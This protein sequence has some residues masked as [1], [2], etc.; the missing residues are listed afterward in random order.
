MRENE[1]KHTVAFPR[2]VST[3]QPFYSF[4]SVQYKLALSPP[5][6]QNITLK[7]EAAICELWMHFF[8]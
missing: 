1:T 7:Q 5:P 8:F 3:L 2:Q 4:I 6:P